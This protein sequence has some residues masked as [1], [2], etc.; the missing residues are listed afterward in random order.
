MPRV[1]ALSRVWRESLLCPSRTTYALDCCL[2][3]LALPCCARALHL[4]RVA[5]ARA[6]SYAVDERINAVETYR[7]FCALFHRKLDFHIWAR[8]SGVSCIVFCLPPGVQTFK[9]I[10]VCW[11]F[12]GLGTWAPCAFGAFGLAREELAAVTFKMAVCKRFLLFL[13]S[14]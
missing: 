6:K 11:L 12:G 13:T 9:L 4:T 7:A 14:S 2:V 8:V 10:L 1:I 5:A 3:A